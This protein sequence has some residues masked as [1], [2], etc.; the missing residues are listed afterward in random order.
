MNREIAPYLAENYSKVG[1][2]SLKTQILPISEL[3]EQR[4]ETKTMRLPVSSARL[5]NIIS[6][7]FGISRKSA[8]EAI[9]RGIVFVNDMEMKKPD[10]FL[11][12]GEKD[13]AQRQ[14]E[15]HI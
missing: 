2:I 3:K 14:G 11:K 5:D 8:S 15:G 10:H 7:V 4:A 9:N 13:S 12:G 6:A 1:R